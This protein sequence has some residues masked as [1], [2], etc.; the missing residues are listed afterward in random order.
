MDHVDTVVDGNL[1]DLVGGE[2]GLY[3]SVLAGFADD[4]GLVCLLPVHAEPV[5]ATVYSHSLE[6]QLVGSTEDTNR[7]FT[8]VGDCV[9]GLSAG[10]LQIRASQHTAYL[11]A[12][13]C[14]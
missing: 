7:D 12:S 10:E 9:K 6:G 4:I 3:G 2:V 11:G 14:S 5:L 13:S 1:D 8:T